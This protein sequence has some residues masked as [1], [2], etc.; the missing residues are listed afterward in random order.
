MKTFSCILYFCAYIFSAI[1]LSMYCSY[2]F[3]LLS[4]LSDPQIVIET[5]FCCRRSKHTLVA[6]GDAL[7]V[8]GGDNG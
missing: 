3:Y 8:F 7:Y 1:R 5:V 6:W 2:L 4:T